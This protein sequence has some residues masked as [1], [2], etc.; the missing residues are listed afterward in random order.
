M[1]AAVQISK[2]TAVEKAPAGMPALDLFFG[3]GDAAQAPP[4]SLAWRLQ[5]DMRAESFSPFAPIVTAPS[6]PASKAVNR[7]WPGFSIAALAHAFL[8]AGVLAFFGS[9]GALHQT[10][11]DAIEVELIAEAPSAPGARFEQQ[12]ASADPQPVPEREP[13]PESVTVA[14]PT[15]EEDA[16]PRIEAV[17][18]ITAPEPN[19]GPEQAEAPV[20][21][22]IADPVTVASINPSLATEA[23]TPVSIP[24][25]NAVARNPAPEKPAIAKPSAA[26]PERP[27]LIRAAPKA[28]QRGVQ[29]TAR[30]SPV[31]ARP[32]SEGGAN[33]RKA[34]AGQNAMSVDAFRAAVLA[35]IARN[36]PSTDL[37]ARAQGVVVVTFGVGAG[38]DAQSPRITRSSGHSVL[39]NAALQTVRRASPFPPPPPGAPRS[40]NVPI[41]FNA[42]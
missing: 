4:V 12:H 9:A 32:N 3:R 30:R 18:P 21:T 42:L 17:D 39:D 31:E 6:A 25:P 23:Q 26:K 36:K 5:C 19:S 13:E 1:T 11:E 20:E 33:G 29:Q 22:I 40:F 35:R 10:A 24:P 8:L 16:G 7:V 37:A 2:L 15:A 27:R 38:G 34:V 41:R 28:P 14:A